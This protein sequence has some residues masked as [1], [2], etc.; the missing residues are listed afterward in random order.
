MDNFIQIAVAELGQKEIVGPENNPRIEE[1]AKEIGV[2]PFNDDETAWC[3][4]FINWVAK[5]ANLKKSEKVNARSW[6]VVGQSADS[7]PSP[8]DIVVFWREKPESW[9]GHVGIFLGFSK[10]G[11]RVFCLGGNQGNQ[12]SI[13]AYPTNTVLGYRRL[14]SEGIVTVPDKELK[15]GDYGDSVKELQ[16]A[17]KS[18]GLDCGT[19]DGDFGPRTEAAVKQ[20]QTMK[21]GLPINGIFDNET[22]ILLLELIN[23]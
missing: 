7:N 16:T 18:I 1:Y 15:K 23:Q 4:I 13:S 8:G 2:W 9:K 6:L 12:V 20:L 10:D 17:L 19:I 3:S 22:R 21:T 5:K 11:E 14:T